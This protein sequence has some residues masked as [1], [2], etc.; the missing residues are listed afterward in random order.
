MIDNIGQCGL[1]VF[2]SKDE[3]INIKLKKKKKKD[4][5]S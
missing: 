4:I 3:P 5:G 2:S 1:L